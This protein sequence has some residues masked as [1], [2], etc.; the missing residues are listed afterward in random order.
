ML[1]TLLVSGTLGCKEVNNVMKSIGTYACCEVMGNFVA[2]GSM[3]Y[4]LFIN[5]IYI[6]NRIFCGIFLFLSILVIPFANVCLARGTKSRKS[7]EK[8]KP[9]SV[10]PKPKKINKNAFSL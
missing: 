4:I 6:M 9:S 1:N 2:A 7:N 5:Y 3:T 8:V 10:P